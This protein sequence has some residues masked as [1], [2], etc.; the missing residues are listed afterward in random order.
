M[1]YV[2][3]LTDPFAEQAEGAQVPDMYSLPTCTQMIR[4]AFTISTT[5]ATGELD[6]VIQP[7]VLATVAAGYGVYSTTDHISG[8]NVWYTS[9][10]GVTF[11]GFSEHGVISPDTLQTY[12]ARYRV[13]SFGFRI[14][15]LVNPQGQQ[16][17]FYVAKVPACNQFAAY[18]STYTPDATWGQYCD[19]YE[20]PGLDNNGY[21]T[22]AIVGLPTATQNMVSSLSLEPGLS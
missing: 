15:T 6:F 12:F 21:L 9:A 20:L 11:D 17:K 3:A 1:Q 5:D 13:V 18:N 19:F 10:A 14:R 7:N 16:G 22:N 4:T 8:G 2:A